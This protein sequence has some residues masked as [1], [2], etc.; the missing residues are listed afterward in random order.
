MET[1][2]SVKKGLV[3]FIAVDES[4]GN[5][6]ESPLFEFLYTPLSS[7]KEERKKKL[8]SRCLLIGPGARWCPAA[9]LAANDF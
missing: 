4:K 6:R 3:G 1:K 9:R 8:I 7:R 5:H 2:K